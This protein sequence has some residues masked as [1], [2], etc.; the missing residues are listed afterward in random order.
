MSNGTL[1]FAGGD[2]TESTSVTLDTEDLPYHQFGDNVTIYASLEQTY[3]SIN[4]A[5]LVVSFFLLSALFQS[6]YT[7][8][9][10]FIEYS[11][12]ASIMTMLIVMQS[13]IWN[14]YAVM[15]CA[16]LSAV[17]MLTGYVADS[18]HK[19][20]Q[21]I[22]VESENRFRGFPWYKVGGSHIIA[23]RFQ[24][25]AIGWFAILVPWI[26]IWA[27]FATALQNNVNVSGSITAIIVVESLFFLS[28]GVVQTLELLEPIYNKDSSWYLSN[29]TAKIIYIILSLTAKTF[30]GWMIAFELFM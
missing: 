30:L 29:Y 15:C 3:A 16:A 8:S 25:H 23:L 24:V 21:A 17:C 22:A 1:I 4:V 7:N 20:E 28:F 19:V 6:M 14:V 10:R 27:S 2:E 13:G 12:S 5:V 11:F 26:C 18:L 9:F